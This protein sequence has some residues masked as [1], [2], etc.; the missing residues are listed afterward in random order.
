[1]PVLI[2]PGRCS[3]YKNEAKAER[4]ANVVSEFAEDG[5]QAAVRYRHQGHLL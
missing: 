1:M 4:Q 2:W 3:V 5:R